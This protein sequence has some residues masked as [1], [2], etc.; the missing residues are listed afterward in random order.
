MDCAKELK[1]VV[2]HNLKVTQKYI[3]QDLDRLNKITIQKQRVSVGKWTS[4]SFD[5]REYTIVHLRQTT[6]IVGGGGDTLMSQSA[7]PSR[8]FGRLLSE[9]HKVS[10]RPQPDALL[11]DV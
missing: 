10:A 7:A 2:M 11:F 8:R 1:A 4:K 6:E 5:Y 9:P 3:E